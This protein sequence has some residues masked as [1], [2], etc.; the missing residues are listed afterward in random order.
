MHLLSTKKVQIRYLI[1]FFLVFWY[2]FY[3]NIKNLPLD[4]T[5]KWVGAEYLILTKEI[6]VV[7]PLCP[8]WELFSSGGETYSFNGNNE[9]LLWNT[10]F[11]A[12]ILAWVLTI[13]YSIQIGTPRHVRPFGIKGICPWLIE[14]GACA[15]D[16]IRNSLKNKL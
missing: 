3:P 10:L 11:S 7:C 8:H 4:I 15:S 14:S 16:E 6:F 1:W 2:K 9:I 5:D 12:W 13:I